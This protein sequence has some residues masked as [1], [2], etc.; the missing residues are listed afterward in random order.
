MSEDAGTEFLGKILGGLLLIW[1]I[2]WVIRWI[3]GKIVEHASVIAWV[4][5]G[6]VF[7]AVLG[8][9]G[10]S[11][12]KRAEAVGKWEKKTA[13]SSSFAVQRSNWERTLSNAALAV[14]ASE[15]GCKLA[16]AEKGRGKPILDGLAQSF[17]EAAK[18][19]R[20]QNTELEEDGP[21]A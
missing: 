17:R 9:I 10:H 6:M 4:G 21:N 7:F 15:K 12:G 18:R 5:M 20:L 3:I 1:G 16:Q 14:Q 13:N 11:L 2:L 19:E 8:I